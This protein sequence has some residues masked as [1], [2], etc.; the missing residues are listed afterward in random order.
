MKHR[1]L[2]PLLFFGLIVAAT[3]PVV[4]ED[5]TLASLRQEIAAAPG[6]A[7]ATITQT[8]RA[9]GPNAALL[10]GPAAALAIQSL[11][12]NATSKQIAAIVFAAVR[13]APDSA[14]RIVRAA[15]S[16]APG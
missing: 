16:V 11:G 13:V 10:A 1:V 6:S 5:A 8:L 15:V 9:A 2:L 12:A 7:V 14:L 4:A 3:H